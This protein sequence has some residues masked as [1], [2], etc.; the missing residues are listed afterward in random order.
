MAIIVAL[1]GQ[2]MISSFRN[3]L[4]Y[5]YQQA[6]SYVSKDITATLDSFNTI[7][8][9]PYYYNLAGDDTVL[10]NAYSFDNFRNAFYGTIYDEATME[11]DRQ[12]DMEKFLQYIQT[13]NS[14][15]LAVHFVG[16]D[17][18]GNELAFH[19][20]D[21]NTYFKDED[22][23]YEFMDVAAWDKT[24]SNIMIIPTHSTA[25]FNRYNEE[26]VT[27]AR[28][29]FDPHGT[30]GN[31]PYV[32]T[33]FIDIDL[34][35]FDSIF[36]SAKNRDSE[37]TYFVST[38]DGSI[39]YSTDSQYIGTDLEDYLA[40]IDQVEK[41][42][43]ISEDVDEYGLTVTAVLN[44]D[45]VFGD[46]IKAQRLMYIVLLVSALLIIF[47][48]VYSSKRLT[49]P[50]YE[51]IDQ[52]AEVEHGNFDIDLNVKS[53]Y[54]IEILAD[55]FNRM[56]QALKQ[57]INQSYVAKLKQNEAELTALKSQIYP[58]FLYNTLE[59]IRMTALEDGN[60][61][62]PEMIES[63][64][65]QIHYLIGPMQDRVSLDD[66]IEIVKKYIYL[67]NCRI[68]GKVQLVI[69]SENQKNIMIPKLVLQPVVE[70]AYVHGIKPKAFNGTIMIS[71]NIV[72]D[73]L[74]INVMDNGVGMD[75]ASI[76]AIYALLQGD[77][78]GI[79]NEYNW[80]SIGLKNVH[81]RIR[82]LYGDEY[83][84]EITSTVGIGT[85][86][87]LTMPLEIRG[88]KEYDRD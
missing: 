68:N 9:L 79:K 25:Y 66:E 16:M 2:T 27:I 77:D 21:Y 5:Q 44:A 73:R 80:Q 83:G 33:L 86:A 23:F 67:L 50:I 17:L 19:Y 43:L 11:S 18:E 45:N 58:H 82:Y 1:V 57:Y 6:I 48:A 53:D 55:R 12:K 7:S 39:I 64:S 72:E 22:L 54:E 70:N 36:W 32:G 29:Y 88:S 15:I 84:I 56:S 46:I 31:L 61:A 26:V 69:N 71:T 59:V 40:S 38:S 62:V 8:K 14:N 28:N 74:E 37:E 10:S 78:P 42:L 87:K 51:I 24:S 13:V 47:G 49:K 65:Q 60:E 34:R 85:N 20:S 30:V 76:D 41:K 35:Q 4:Q 75:Q 3:S 52:M 63:L 81:D